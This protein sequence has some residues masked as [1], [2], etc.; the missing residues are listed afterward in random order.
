MLALG[1]LYDFYSYHYF[2]VEFFCPIPLTSHETDIS[3]NLS[4]YGLTALEIERKYV[5][6][7]FVGLAR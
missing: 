5:F 3:Q 6:G 1:T 2:M 7:N 4:K